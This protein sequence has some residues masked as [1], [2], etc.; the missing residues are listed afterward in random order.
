MSETVAELDD[1]KVIWNFKNES[2]LSRRGG[3]YRI[4]ALELISSCK[5]VSNL[6]SYTSRQMMK[7]ST[8]VTKHAKIVVEMFAKVQPNRN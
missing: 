8:A 5:R 6:K 4:S 7:E 3:R 2:D 1:L